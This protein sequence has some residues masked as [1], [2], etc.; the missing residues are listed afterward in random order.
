MI[1]IQIAGGLGNQMQQYALSRKLISLGKEV[2]LDLSW[3]DK[4]RQKGILAPRNFELS[5]FTN[6]PYLECTDAD[7]DRFLK[8]SNID[9]A[10]Y[11]MFPKKD[12]IFREREMYHP[13]V[14]D[15][16]DKY[17]QG[18][19]LCQKYYDD[20]MPQ[21]QELFR[22]PIH[23]YTEEQLKNAD[24]INEMEQRPSVSVHIRRGDYLDPENA[25]LFGNIATDK[26]YE[27]AMNFFLSKNKDT[28]FYIF[29]N[30]TEFA[31][32]KYSD[33]DRYT[34][35]D[36]NTGKYSLLDMELMSHCW[37]NICANS[38]FSFWGARLNS[39]EDHIAVRT[40]KMRNNQDATPGIMHDYWHD[41]VL[42]DENGQIV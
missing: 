17:L 1:I 12:K 34:V 13:E 28:H 40:F 33:P 5:Y 26:Y 39:R 24:M 3:F 4:D 11:K 31:K 30:D 19:F 6:L 18:F 21:L 8:R 29:T 42:I 23:L 35:I 22:F 38:T 14:F 41:W 27:A 15:F 9:K 25:A 2:K 36:W 20:I 37:G 32:Q 10:I 16:D 7:R